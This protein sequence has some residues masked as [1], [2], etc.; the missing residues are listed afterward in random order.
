MLASSESLVPC[1]R[2]IF[3]TFSARFALSEVRGSA[4]NLFVVV[5]MKVYLSI[6]NHQLTSFRHSLFYAPRKYSVIQIIFQ[7]ADCNTRRV[8][9]TSV[10]L[11]SFGSDFFVPPNTIDFAAAYSNLGGKLLENYAVLTMIVATF[12]VY[13][14][15]GIWARYKR[16]SEYFLYS[17]S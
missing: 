10:H 6:K 13:V 11:S 15:V 17:I 4:W 14:V 16:R 2:S 5:Y 1:C 7:L 12:A 9:C 8:S 3:K